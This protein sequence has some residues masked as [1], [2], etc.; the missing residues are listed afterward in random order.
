MKKKN[1]NILTADSINNLDDFVVSL[2]A[3]TVSLRSMEGYQA[4][5]FRKGLLDEDAQE[6]SKTICWEIRRLMAL[7]QQML[8]MIQEIC[9]V[10][11][12]E[13]LKALKKCIPDLEIKT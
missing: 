4:T 9:P 13:V 10:N 3:C 2:F 7:Y 8:L 5:A 1:Y 11:E 12:E 6:I